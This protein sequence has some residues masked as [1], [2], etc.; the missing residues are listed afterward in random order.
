MV[1][2]YNYL[3]YALA[4]V[5]AALIAT[6]DPIHTTLSTKVALPSAHSTKD[7][8]AAKGWKQSAEE[9][10]ERDLSYQGT[11]PAGSLGV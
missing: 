5:L 6:T 2:L 11:R 9:E 4:A 10:C 8:L 3:G 1:Q 7:T